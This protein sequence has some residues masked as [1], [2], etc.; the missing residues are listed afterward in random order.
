[1]KGVEYSEMNNGY[2]HWQEKR[3]KPYIKMLFGFLSSGDVKDNCLLCTGL[4]EFH[5]FA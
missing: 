1:M 2:G 4:K 3:E 5:D